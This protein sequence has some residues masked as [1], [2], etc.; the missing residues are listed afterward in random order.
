MADNLPG[1]YKKNG[2]FEGL[3]FNSKNNWLDVF[4]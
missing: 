4:V 2:T 3:R 1:A